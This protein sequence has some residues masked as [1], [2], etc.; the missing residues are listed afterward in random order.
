MKHIS[1]T[2]Q[3]QLG[4]CR[5][6]DH[7][8]FRTKVL[9]LKRSSGGDDGGGG[10]Y[11]PT[12]Y[13]T[14]AHNGFLS[15]YAKKGIGFQN[16]N[17]RASSSLLFAHRVARSFARFCRV[18][19]KNQIKTNAV[20]HWNSVIKVAAKCL[21]FSTFITSRSNW[22]TF[23]RSGAVFLKL[24]HGTWTW[25]YW[26]DIDVGVAAVED[27]SLQIRSNLFCNCFWFHSFVASAPFDAPIF[28]VSSCACSTVCQQLKMVSTWS[29]WLFYSC[30]L[31]GDEENAVCIVND[32]AD[33][34]G[35]RYKLYSSGP[36]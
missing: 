35:C 15:I 33:V 12:V 36:G 5:E 25:T 4:T 3:A 17:F 27:R 7:S 20:K 2:A 31:P 13:Y 22:K 16:S 19:L 29:F 21:Y 26:A 14:V 9:I 11:L 8:A 18:I 30:E 24:E 1:V 34:I 32:V 23:S 10:G 28:R 6:S